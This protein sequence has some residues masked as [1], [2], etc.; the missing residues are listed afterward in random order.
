MLLSGTDLLQ[1]RALKAEEITQGTG[2]YA[3]IGLGASWL[4]DQ[5][6]TYP[7]S[8]DSRYTYGGGFSG[9]AALGYDFGA[10]R[11]EVS[12][13]FN[14]YSNG[15]L[16]TPGGSYDLAGGSTNLNSAYLS[17]YWDLPLSSRWI[18]YLGGGAGYTNYGYSS[19]SFAGVPYK[20]S[21]VG[22]FGYQAKA[23]LSYVLSRRSDL[24]LEAT[25]QGGSPFRF[26][27]EKYG[28]LNSWG[29]RL[30]LRWRFGGAAPAAALAATPE[31][32][33]PQPAPVL[34]APEPATEPVR[35]LW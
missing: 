14:T 6:T 18:P 32:L 1:S 35:G 9:D 3:A 28:A 21:N 26:G 29:T 15:A 27:S 20:G 2:F 19:G 5:S 8:I 12:Y 34:P 11:S 17:A 31:P 23:G 22:T 24:Y 7:G 13:A 10:I 4:R 33:P 16:E 30:G 25:Y